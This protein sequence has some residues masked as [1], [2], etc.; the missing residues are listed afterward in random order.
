MDNENKFVVS[1]TAAEAKILV[2]DDSPNLRKS[3]DWYLSQYDILTDLCENGEKAIEAIKTKRYDMVFMDNHM[4]P[5]ISGIEAVSHIREMGDSDL[6]FKNL[7]IIA[8][9]GRSYKKE[10]FLQNG[11]NDFLEKLSHPEQLEAILV[12]WLPQEKQI[13]KEN[14]KKNVAKAK[15]EEGVKWPFGCWLCRVGIL[16]RFCIV[17]PPYR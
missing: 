11:Y 10:M 16:K 12:K 1:F 6:Y 15:N 9:D 8:H 4:P 13:R 3:L 2:V 14:N 7:P 17:C 5:G